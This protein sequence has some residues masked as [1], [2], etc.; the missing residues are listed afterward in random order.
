MLKEASR[1]RLS[2]VFIVVIL[3][4]LPLIPLALDPDAPLRFRMQ[5]FISRSL[6][7]TFYLAA[8]ALYL[9]LT[10]VS[11]AGLQRLERAASRG[12]RRA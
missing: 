11:T 7:F 6:G 12:V 4:M 1:S 3:V 2:L 9:G 8:A 10:I 5:T